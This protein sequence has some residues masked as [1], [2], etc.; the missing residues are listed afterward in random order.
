LIISQ[1]PRHNKVQHSHQVTRPTASKIRHAATIDS[2]EFSIRCSGGNMKHMRLGLVERWH[3]D[4]GAERQLREIDWH[5]YHQ[6]VA[7]PLKSIVFFNTHEHM[8]VTTL[9]A[10]GRINF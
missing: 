7:V 9:A 3:I 4:V 8:Q 5:Q 6:V 1:V 2:E 10:A